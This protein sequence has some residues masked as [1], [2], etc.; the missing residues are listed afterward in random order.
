MARE[1]DTALG[2]LQRL[3]PSIVGGAVL[4]AVILACSGTGASP[5]SLKTAPASQ[6]QLWLRFDYTADRYAEPLPPGKVLVMAHYRTE[7]DSS[8][9]LAGGQKLICDGIDMLHPDHSD[10]STYSKTYGRVLLNRQPPGGKHICVYTDERGQQ[11]TAVI[12]M[13]TGQLAIVSPRA[14]AH[15]PIP[16]YIASALTTPYKPLPI[17]YTRPTLS[18][19]GH[20]QLTFTVECRMYRGGACVDQYHDSY[21][22]DYESAGSDGAL[23]FN[24]PVQPDAYNIILE[25]KGSVDLSLDA[26][27]SPAPQG[28]QS[29]HVELRDSVVNEITWVYSG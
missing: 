10:D 25:S 4:V 23:I 28:F 20:G 1:R 15:M 5:V 11:T 26:D 6:L 2:R 14:G 7:H 16:P 12:P 18:S 27:W 8:I 19:G 17:T 13:P 29:V 9:A 22:P 21:G 24:Y 3:L